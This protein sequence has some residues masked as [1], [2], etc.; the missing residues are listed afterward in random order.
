[1]DECD[2][3]AAAVEVAREMPRPPEEGSGRPVVR[4]ESVALKEMPA[5]SVVHMEEGLCGLEPV[6]SRRVDLRN[7]TYKHAAQTEVLLWKPM[8]SRI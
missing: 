3:F 6:E 8:S 4:E 1:M 5:S 7:I 2:R